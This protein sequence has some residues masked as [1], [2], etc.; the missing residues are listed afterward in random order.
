MRQKALLLT[1]DHPVRDDSRAARLLEFFGVSYQTHRTVEFRLPETGATARDVPYR[2]IATA[3]SFARVIAALQNSDTCNS[4]AHKIHSVFLCSNGDPIALSK[5]ISQLSGANISVRRG[6]K[7]HMQW[8]IADDPEGMCGAMRGLRVHPAPATVSTCDFFEANEGSATPMISAGDKAAFL[9]I[10]WRGIPFFISSVPLLDID[11]DLATRNFDIR[12]HLFS[13][14]P[15]VSYIRWAFPQTSWH[16]SESSACLVIDDPLLKPSYGFVCYRELLALMKRLRFATSIAFI[17]WNW[18]RSDPNVVQLFKENP[19]NYS[20]CIHGCDHTVGE[21]DTSDRQ[22]LRAIASEAL[23]RMSLH[24]RGTGLQHDRIMVFPQGA[25]SGEAIVELKRAGFDAVVNTEVHSNP[26]LNGKVKISDVWDVAVMSYGDFPIYTRRYPAQGVENF[27]FD[28]LLGKP[29]LVVIHH[30]FCSHGY[31]RLAELIE[32]LNALR[33]PL[34]WRCL[35]EIVRRT[36]RRRELTADSIEI[37]MHC[38]QVSIENRSDHVKN[39]FVRRR[40]HDANSIESLHAGSR[41]LAWDMNDDYI[42]FGLKLRP[43]ETTLLTLRFRPGE[44]LAQNGRNIACSAKTMLRRYLC[45]A[46]DNYLMR[47][48]ARIGLLS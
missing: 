30:D 31:S 21:F 47:A 7:S 35:G 43:Q 27:A 38:N 32:Q 42:E 2:L 26:P 28:L 44:P 11:A 14:V 13:A 37:Q 4:F 39:Y 18:R 20:L 41:Q 15:F 3:E 24:A 46:R 40:E 17:P 34:A 29:C 48:R 23:R 5:V 25:F 45:E 33:V 9:K 22:W 16:A 10:S 19:D 1:G 8:S 6:A 12:D 36:Y